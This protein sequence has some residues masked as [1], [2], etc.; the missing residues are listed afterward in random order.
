MAT[1]CSNIKTSFNK[2]SDFS[3][4]TWIENDNALEQWRGVM[5]QSY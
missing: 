5:Y 2:L 1:A 4:V 3:M